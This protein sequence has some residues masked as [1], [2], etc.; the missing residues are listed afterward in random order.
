METGRLEK[1][2][3]AQREVLR[4]W[5]ERK[6]AKEIAIELGIT[7]WAVNERLR[8]A[9]RALRV[10]T[11][12]EAARLLVQAEQGAAYKRDVYEP[13]RLAETDPLGTIG[14]TE[15]DGNWSSQVSR[16]TTVQEDQVPNVQEDQVPNEVDRSWRRLRLPFPRYEG[17]RNDLT[18]GKRVLWIGA[19]ALGIVL[20][21]SALIAVAMGAGRIL[22]HLI[23]FSS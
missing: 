9:R 11:S 19:L 4:R 2:T 23:R 15:R 14:T 22:N 7:H 16:G 6:S 20:I 10:G 5:N 17:D 3:E 1:L 18:A 8:T 13:L 21:A 12:Q